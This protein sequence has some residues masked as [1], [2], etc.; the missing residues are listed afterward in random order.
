MA[1]GH[2]SS[3]PSDVASSAEAP[4]VTVVPD[5]VLSTPTAPVAAA[6][7]ATSRVADGPV[8]RS[9]ADPVP[10]ETQRGPSP[11]ANDDD[12]SVPDVVSDEALNVEIMV[13]IDAMAGVGALV[14]VSP[15]TIASPLGAASP[16][17]DVEETD[18]DVRLLD[19]ER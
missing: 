11:P 9:E 10:R 3:L 4:S 1:G 12:R 7:S 15:V 8:G 18:A 14:D 5:G 6:A 17:D 2:G 19:E 13:D 16:V